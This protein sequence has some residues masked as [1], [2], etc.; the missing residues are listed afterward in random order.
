MKHIDKIMN[1][2]DNNSKVITVDKHTY[3]LENGDV[4]EHTFE[5]SDSITVEEFQYLLDNT[6]QTINNLLNTVTQ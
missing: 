2:L 1:Y 4:F 3:T 5:I 6:K